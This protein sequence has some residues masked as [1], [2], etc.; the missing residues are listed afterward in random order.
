MG[1]LIN[2]Q[3]D[4]DGK[5]DTENDRQRI[6]G[7]HD[8]FDWTAMVTR[9]GTITETVARLSEVLQTSYELISF[10]AGNDVV[11]CRVWRLQALLAV[12]L[13]SEWHVI[14]P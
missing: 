3:L 2:T 5:R 1:E 6:A 13:M 7:S 12:D 14:D 8:G 11:G 9:I 4:G 10:L